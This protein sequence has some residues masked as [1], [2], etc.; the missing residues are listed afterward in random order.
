MQYGSRVDSSGEVIKDNEVRLRPVAGEKVEGNT[1]VSIG[2][3]KDKDGNPTSNRAA[4]EFKQANGTV[5]KWSIF[6]PQPSTER[7]IDKFGKEVGNN[8]WQL[9]KM[10]KNIRHLATKI[11]SEDEYFAAIEANGGPKSFVDFINRV[12]KVL[13]PEVAGKLFTMK[14]VYLKGYVSI[15]NFPHWIATPDNTDALIT[16]KSDS[17]VPEKPSATPL[18]KAVSSPD[19]F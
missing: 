6:E 7:I 14:F 9:D 18:T 19:A 2:M 11:V 5:V 17:Y 16:T 15:P 10:N 12:S 4:V 1:I 13:M 3:D 8:D